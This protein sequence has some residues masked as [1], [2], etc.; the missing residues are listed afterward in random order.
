[1]K[2]MLFVIPV[3]LGL[4]ASLA[5]NTVQGAG[6]LAGGDG[7]LGKTYTLYLGTPDALNFTLNKL[8]YLP[9]RFITDPGT[10]DERDFLPAAGKK[11]VVMHY[12][13]QNPQKKD[14]N[15]RADYSL[16]F[17]GVDS[18]NKDVPVA[19]A[20]RAYDEITRKSA[21]M[22]LK[23]A[24][25]INVISI[26]ELDSRASLPKLMVETNKATKAVWRY[27]LSGKIAPLTDPF[28][29]PAVKDGSA[30]LDQGIPLKL[31]FYVPAREVDFKVNSVQYSPNDILDRKVPAGGKILL[32]NLTFRNPHFRPFK[33]GNAFPPVQV[34]VF[35]QDDMAGGQAGKLYFAS[36]DEQLVGELGMN[37]EIGARLAVALPGGLTPKR[38]E[39]T[40]PNK[41]TFNVDL[42]EIK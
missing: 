10:N 23:P 33:I 41:R 16:K 1:M 42:S 37:K 2:K 17:T 40:D 9:G 8:E 22:T 18:N 38:L 27:D 36:R 34:K 30:A 15:F 24:Q 25:K 20:S 11:L 4:T 32:I 13:V 14:I 3:L 31:N 35:D 28:V 6:Q 39:F 5:Q 19:R 12:S 21:S 7:A 26:M 29:D